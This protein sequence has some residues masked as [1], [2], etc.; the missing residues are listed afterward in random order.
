MTF[1]NVFSYAGAL[2]TAGAAASAHAGQVQIGVDIPQ[3]SVAEFHKPYVAGW[4]ETAAGQ[5]SGDLFVWYD[6][7]K[8]NNGGAKWLSDLRTWWRKSGRNLNL[9]VDGLSGAT[10]APGRQTLTLDT[11]ATAFKNLKP[12]AYQLVVEAARENGGHSLVK[13]PFDWNGKAFSATGRTTGELGA[14]TL[15][16][17]P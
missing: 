2:L 16:Y 9:P 11:G 13:L 3:A 17:K 7:R 6:Q 1:K 8:P 5:P 14:V 12:G 4:I 10:H 15:S